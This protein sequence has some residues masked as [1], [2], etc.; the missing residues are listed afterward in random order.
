MIDNH[1]VAKVSYL[2]CVVIGLGRYDKRHVRNCQK[3]SKF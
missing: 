3:V 2:V 1:N